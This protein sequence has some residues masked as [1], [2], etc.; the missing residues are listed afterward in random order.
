MIIGDIK[1]LDK[2]S[3]EAILKVEDNNKWLICFSH[4]CMYKIGDYL[5]EPLECSHVYDIISMD[6]LDN[7]INKINEEFAYILKGEIVDI[8]NG[9]VKVDTFFLHI[10]ENIIPKD[11]LNNQIIQFQS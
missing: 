9:I 10:D 8:E 1:W 2:D 7:N 4:P 11:I 5:D 3:R 6:S